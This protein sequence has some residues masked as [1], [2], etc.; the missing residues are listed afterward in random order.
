MIK[1]Q[2][3]LE[4]EMTPRLVMIGN[5]HYSEVLLYM[6]VYERIKEKN[7]FIPR[8]WSLVGRAKGLPSWHST[9]TPWP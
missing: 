2:Q 1:R 9:G 8:S 5:V 6:F 4:E 3:D 7:G